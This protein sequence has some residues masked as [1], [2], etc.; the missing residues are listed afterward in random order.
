MFALRDVCSRHEKECRQ[1]IVCSSCGLDFRSRNALYQHA[2]RKGHTLPSSGKQ[3]SLRPSNPTTPPQNVVFVPVPTSIKL[4]LPLPKKGSV[5]S[6]ATQTDCDLPAVCTPTKLVELQSSSS[7]T[8]LTPSFSAT[9]FNHVQ[10]LTSPLELLSLGT[11]T[12]VFPPQPL[13]PEDITSLVVSTQTHSTQVCDFG[14]QTNADRA[15]SPQTT[16]SG[17]PTFSTYA[18]SCYNSHPDPSTL[19]LVEFGTQTC[20]SSESYGISESDTVDFGTQTNAGMSDFEMD[21][22]LFCRNLLPPDCLDFGT[23]TLDFPYD[24]SSH[25][26]HM[27]SHSSSD[28]RDQSS[29]T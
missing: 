10:L 8:T 29:Q 20:L 18:S 22:T 28:T 7:Q 27:C 15:S 23:Q 3:T 21:D 4:V 26:D 25:S 11:Q 6:S 2:K 24:C 17:P 19:D 16:A 12:N 5:V 14:T 9:S 13:Q 1:K